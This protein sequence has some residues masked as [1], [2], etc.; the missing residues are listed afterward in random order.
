[1]KTI[2]F[3]L[4]V[5]G[6]QPVLAEQ[7]HFY[8][9]TY[10]DHSSSKGIYEGALDTSTGQLGSILL[11]VPAAD[12]SFL[13]FDPQEKNLYAAEE[14]PSTGQVQAL[15]RK[16]DGSLSPLNTQPAG[17][18]GTCHVSVDPSGHDVLIANYGSGSIACFPRHVDGSLGSQTTFIPLHGSGPDAKRQKSAHAH[19]I[20][21]SPDDAFVYVCDLGS[22]AVW[23]FKF[24]AGSGT[25]APS[26]PAWTSV[27]PGSGARH[28]V[29]SADSKFVYVANEMG[30]SVSAF[31]RDIGS[32]K[33]T[34]F[35]TIS[36]LPEGLSATNVTTAEIAFHP[37]GKWLY[38]S[39]RGCD[40]ISV[41]NRATSGRLK[42]GQS[43]SAD[44][45][46]PRNFAIDPTGR[47]MIVAGQGD[48]RLAVLEIDPNTGRLKA[49]AQSADVG[50][51]VCI[52]FEN[53]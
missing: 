31:T 50:S 44:V 4:A 52:L 23:I 21:V 15:A 5:L 48:N 35:Q 45:K 41:F 30:H 36:T 12:P 38:V 20:Y 25:L 13:A 2:C 17:G 39:N 53:R 8:I 11:A 46:T 19:S 37:S 28:L 14:S 43:I 40:T 34:L 18:Q 9:G 22:D 1:M 10:T 42:L 29:F 7:V 6:L 16:S 51:P 32:G 3:L 33:L 24:D 27:L 47:W 26:R 49:T